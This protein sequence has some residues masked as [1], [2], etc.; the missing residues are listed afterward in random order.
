MFR[1]LLLLPALV[2]LSLGALGLYNADRESQTDFIVAGVELVAGIALVG[3][4]L[5]I[6]RRSMP[7]GPTPDSG[8]RAE[9]LERLQRHTEA[10]RGAED[11]DQ[12]WDPAEGALPRDGNGADADHIRENTHA[13][14]AVSAA[15]A[16]RMDDHAGTGDAIPGVVRLPPLMLLNITGGAGPADLESAPPLGSREDV[17]ARLRDI[18]PDLEIGTGG[19]T[20]HSGPDHSVRFDLGA[21]EPVHTV[22]I[23]AAGRT[24]ISLVRW[25][26]EST[27]W[28]AF[29][30][31]SGRFV[32]PDA[33]E[34]IAVRD[35]A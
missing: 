31:K 30:P 24:G 33:L 26:L 13:P 3:I 20:E 14:M 1:L 8:D 4:A 19:R 29:V 18:V 2:L 12:T 17:L 16:D 25:L 34:S 15:A 32:E 35:D 21:R 10:F 7:P 11:N 22:V 28:R 5:V 9:V 27:G 23:E 6:G